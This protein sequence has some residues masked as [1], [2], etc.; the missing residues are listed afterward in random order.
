VKTFIIAE[1]G[2]NHDGDIEKAKRL[3]KSA[4]SSGADAVKF[5][6]FKA[7]Q[8]VTSNSPKAR[9]QEVATGSGTQFEMLKLLELSQEQFI[10]LNSYCMSLGIEFM[11]TPFD[12]DSLE[13]LVSILKVKRI[14]LSSGD[15]TNLPLVYEV[16]KFKI[17][18]IIS[19]GGSTIEDIDNA[20]IAWSL[21]RNDVVPT[22]KAFIKSE[23]DRL[24]EI[25]AL[26][27]RELSIL[28]C[29]TQYPA[30]AEN[31]NLRVISTYLN[32]YPCAIGFSDHSTGYE[33]ALGAI[34][35]GAQ[36]IEKHITENKSDPG[37]D[38]MASMEINDFTLLVN[39]MR[40]LEKSLGAYE[41]YPTF[42]ELETIKIA[43]KSLVAAR[44]ISEGSKLEPGDLIALRPLGG[45]A[46][47]NYWS[48]IGATA[49]CNISKG[50]FLDDSNISGNL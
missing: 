44:D 39:S 38:H 30:N 4:K 48:L 42:E 14:K 8:L 33:A 27:L 46:P 32:R 35:L 41:K 20:V 15:L 49:T 7:E 18:T 37:P 10:E 40:L 22:K 2:V 43:R 34:A 31:L 45:F 6:T 23:M 26:D 25:S 28:Q 47:S 19:T 50:E 29:T 3:I 17:P 21:G 5:Q 13:F 9:Y 36:L 11:S 12:V 24:A 16:G 1:V